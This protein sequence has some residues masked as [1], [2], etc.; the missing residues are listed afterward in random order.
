MS[1]G[2]PIKILLV[3]DEEHISDVIKLNLELE[4]YGVDLAIN[5]SIAI[6]KFKNNSYDLIILDVMLPEV[7]GF[8]VCRVIRKEDKTTPILFLTAKSSGDDR[9]TGL[10][11]GGDDYLVKPFNLEELLLRVDKLIQRTQPIITIQKEIEIY[12]F[13][14]NSINFKTY[15]AT[16]EGKTYELTQREVSLLKLLIHRKNEV[17]SRDEILEKVWGEDTFPSTRTIDNYIL[18]LRKYFEKNPRTPVYFHSI[19]GVGYKFTN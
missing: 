12:S 18:V 1:N 5:G 7:D 4:S 19:R 6:E 2:S 14:D 13:G 8:D 16:S 10:K 15:T 17:V 3:E 9:V 11:I